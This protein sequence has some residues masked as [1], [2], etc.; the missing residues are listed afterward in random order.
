MTEREMKQRKAAARKA[1]QRKARNRR[2]LT[3]VALMLVVCIA[4]IGGTIAWLTDTT[5]EV[6]NTFSPSNIGLM[7]EEENS[8]TFKIIPGTSVAKD[9]KVTITNDVPAYLFVQ[10]D[11]SWTKT[12]DA[13]AE[14]AGRT[15]TLETFL[16]YSLKMTGWTRGQ[17]TGEGKDGVPIN[18]LYR[19]VGANDTE[20]S[21]YLL[22]GGTDAN[23]NGQVT[24]KDTIVKQM[25][26]D[27]QT[28]EAD[29]YP[30]LSFKAYAIQKDGMVNVADAWSKVNSGS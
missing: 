8:D 28:L 27:L 2:V 30:K 23:L 4:S 12:F 21:W 22:T 9:P 14:N 15:Y 6:V 16:D 19:E 18:V 17:G 20:K 26:D 5:S 10:V 24:Y 13:T 7:L 3:T 29:D 1:R 11:E 25:M